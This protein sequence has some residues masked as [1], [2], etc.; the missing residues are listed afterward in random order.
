[1][2]S[3]KVS[4]L[5]FRVQGLGVLTNRTNMLISSTHR[6]FVYN[7]DPFALVGSFI[8]QPGTKRGSRGSYQGLRNSEIGGG[9]GGGGYLIGSLL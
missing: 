5:G 9:G 3:S 4:G 1:M 7:K 6:L 8:R 2:P